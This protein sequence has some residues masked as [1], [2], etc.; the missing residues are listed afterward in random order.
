MAS[1]MIGYC[2]SIRCIARYGGRAAADV[3]NAGAVRWQ[4]P[5]YVIDP[6]LRGVRAWRLNP[7]RN[8][9]ARQRLDDDRTPGTTAARHVRWSSQL[10]AHRSFL[11]LGTRDD[12]IATRLTFVSVRYESAAHVVR[13][14]QRAPARCRGCPTNLIRGCTTSCIDRRV[15][16]ARDEQRARS[17]AA[18]KSPDSSMEQ[19][20]VA[21]S[22]VGGQ[23]AREIATPA[24]PQR[25]SRRAVSRMRTGWCGGS[26]SRRRTSRSTRRR[27]GRSGHAPRPLRPEADVPRAPVPPD[28]RGSARI[29]AVPPFAAAAR[30]AALG[31][32]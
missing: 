14:R 28:L 26:L 17:A 2:A 31:P 25:I 22:V 10:H 3:R 15:A 8:G 30:P 23:A 12:A 11:A 5:V 18:C 13:P 6:A 4:R 29:A 7:M 32:T 21:M 20:H 27:S 1:L 24:L 19:L 16:A 9:K